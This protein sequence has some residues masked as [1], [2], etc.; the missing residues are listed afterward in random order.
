MERQRNLWV[1]ELMV[2]LIPFKW[3]QAPVFGSSPN[4]GEWTSFY[5]CVS[6]SNVRNCTDFVEQHGSA[7][8][9]SNKHQGRT[10]VLFYELFFL[11]QVLP[12]LGIRIKI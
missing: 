7:F 9:Y 5:H 2:T 6:H 10:A 11:L 1:P 3:G 12:G 8:S 4:S